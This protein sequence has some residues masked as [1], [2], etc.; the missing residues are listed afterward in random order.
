MKK[1][2]YVPRVEAVEAVAISRDN[3][4]EAAKWTKGVVTHRGVNLSYS[5]TGQ[6][7]RTAYVVIGEV[8]VRHA[9]G[10]FQTYSQPDFDKTFEPPFTS[11][12]AVTIFKEN[13]DA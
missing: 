6:P 4:E 3:I 13:P 10:M 1:L 2:K 5:P 7:K 9:D 12:D 8:L 11:P